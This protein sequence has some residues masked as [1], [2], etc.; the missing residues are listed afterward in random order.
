MSPIVHIRT[1]TWLD[2][3]IATLRMRYLRW[4]LHD[5]DRYLRQLE[6]AVV[7]HR[8]ESQRLRCELAHWE[9]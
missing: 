7:A 9:R 1:R 5:N 4:Q 6:R 8:R 3:L 2:N